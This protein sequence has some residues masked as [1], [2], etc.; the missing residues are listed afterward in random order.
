MMSTFSDRLRQRTRRLAL[1]LLLLAVPACGL[2]DYEALMSATQER[3]ERFREEKKYLD[4]P[5]QMP[6]RKKEDQEEPVADVFFRPPKGIQSKPEAINDL[7]WRYSL[8]TGSSFVRVEMAFASDSKDF[9]REV[10]NAH[11]ATE[12]LAPPVRDSTLPFDTW[13][14]HDAQ[15]GYSV[16]ILNAANTRTQV[17]VI[18]VFPKGWRDNLRPV[19][20]TSLRSLAVDQQVGP[21]RQRY[22][23]KSPWRLTGA[24]SP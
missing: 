20:N 5:V 14:F 12:Q 6:T 21:A 15:F 19:M 8:R 3:E 13:E 18:Y 11:T 23:K 7:L 4:E 16:N 24:A 10:L 17:A 1:A 22:N 9:A 2:S